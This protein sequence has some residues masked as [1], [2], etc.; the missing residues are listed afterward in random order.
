MFYS[1][2][3]PDAEFANEAR[4]LQANIACMLAES[5]SRIK[6]IISD[7][8]AIRTFNNSPLFSI[9]EYENL[10]GAGSGIYAIFCLDDNLYADP[11]EWRSRL[12]FMTPIYIGSKCPGSRKGCAIDK[13][14]PNALRDRMRKHVRSLT[15]ANLPLSSFHAKAIAVK[16]SAS[17]LALEGNLISLYRPLWNIELEGFG[18]EGGTE[19]RRISP[20]DQR[21]PGRRL[22]GGVSGVEP[23]LRDRGRTD[24]PLGLISAPC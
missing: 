2:Y 4:S 8:S 23:D 7:A 10:A 20:W 9:A 15:K 13:A 14:F 1:V 22:A 12:G 17:A 19:G 24:A 21:H 18:R 11:P 6:T 5:L 3:D 16:G